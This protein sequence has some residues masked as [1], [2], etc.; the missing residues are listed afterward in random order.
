MSKNIKD[1]EFFLRLVTLLHGPL[2]QSLLSV[3]HNKQ[4]DPSYKGLPEDP[5]ELYK[6]LST[7]HRGIINRLRKQGILKN[8]Q[9]EILLPTNG[10]NKTY[11]D[12]F[13]VKLLLILIINNCT[14]LPPPVNGWNN[15]IPLDSDTSVAANVLRARL[16]RI[17]LNHVDAKSINKTVFQWKWTEGVNIIQE[18]GGSIYKLNILKTMLLRKQ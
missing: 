12:A 16:L 2:K 10:D 5:T 14:T 8:N 9:L 13:D 18:L 15:K 1:V 11:S 6:E 7:V 17:Y 4:N 3:L